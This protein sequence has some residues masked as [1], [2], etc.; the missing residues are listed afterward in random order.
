[1]AMRKIKGRGSENG[2]EKK[3]NS[4]NDFCLKKLRDET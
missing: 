4:Y 2:E 1:M 3:R